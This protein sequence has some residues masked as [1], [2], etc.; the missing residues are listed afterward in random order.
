MPKN[1]VQRLVIHMPDADAAAGR[2]GRFLGEIL[3][4]KLRQSGLAPAQQAAVLDLL[5][6]RRE[7]EVEG[8]GGRECAVSRR[9]G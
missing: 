6:A 7:D 8:E 5:L 3:E 1:H 9:P 2:A 4:R